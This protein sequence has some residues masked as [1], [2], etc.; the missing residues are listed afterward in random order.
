[1]SRGTAVIKEVARVMGDLVQS[2]RWKPRRSIMFC[3]WGAEE[4]GL[5]GS[6]EWVEQYVATLRERAVAYIN[7]DIA[8]DGK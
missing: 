5:I 7:V 6:T 3:S 2:G 4:Y 8:V 1:P